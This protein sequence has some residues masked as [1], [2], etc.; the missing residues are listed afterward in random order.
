M[1]ILIDGATRVLV[2]GITGFQ[3]RMDTRYCLEYGTRI[4]AGVTPGRGG[5][6]VHGVPVFNTVKSALAKHPADAAVLYVPVATLKDALAEALD[7]GIK[8]ILATTENVPRHDAAEMVAA[9]RSSGARLIG[10]NTNGMVSAGQSKLAG[11]GGDRAA[12]I[13]VPGRIGVV[14]R[15]GGM[16][17]EISWTLKRAG[18]GV[19]TCVSMGGDPITGMRMVEYIELFDADP[20]TDAIVLFGEPGGTHEQ[21]VAA[22]IAGGRIQ[23]PVVALISGEFQER[24]PKGMSFG[25]VTAMIDKAGDSASEKRRVLAE[26]GATVVD[27][28]DRIPAA[29]RAKRKGALH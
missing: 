13:Y 27:S 1:S 28:L 22:A 18:L 6:D 9:A 24:Y 21:D 14:S 7:A 3:G 23:K 15:S 8:V 11:I 19:S 4:V 5:D 2:Q 26:S 10:F 25:H 16:S 17:A 20:E 12:Q 29:V